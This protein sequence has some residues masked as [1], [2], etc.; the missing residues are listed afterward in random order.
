MLHLLPDQ[1][2]HRR[3]VQLLLLKVKLEDACGQQGRPQQQRSA[4]GKL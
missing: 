4:L 1:L 3:L 2:P